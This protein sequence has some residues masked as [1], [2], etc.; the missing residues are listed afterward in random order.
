MEAGNDG[1]RGNDRSRIRDAD[2]WR[3]RRDLG[4]RCSNSRLDAYRLEKETP[5]TVMEGSAII[6]CKCIISFRW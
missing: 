6:F 5:K 4:W 2:D 1:D 3:T